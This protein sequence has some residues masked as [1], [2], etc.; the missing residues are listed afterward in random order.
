METIKNYLDN[1]FATL[2]KNDETL[3]LKEELLYN[4]EDK[5]NEL[6]ENG[7]TENEAIG[8]VISEF[9]NI[10]ELLEEFHI[11]SVEDNNNIRTIS[12][13]EAENFMMDKE[14]YGIITAIGVLLC[15]LAPAALVFIE[16]IISTNMFNFGVYGQ[17]S[18]VIGVAVL[19]IL[20]AIAV[21][22]F[23]YSGINLEKYKY[24]EGDFKLPHHVKNKIEKRKEEFASTF[25]GNSIAGVVICVLSPVALII[26]SSIKVNDYDLSNYG[27]VILLVMVAVAVFMFVRVGSVK[28]SYNMLLQVED[29]SEKSKKNSKVIGA[30]AAVVWPVATAIFLISGLMFGAWSICWIIFP[31]TGILFGAFSGAYSIMK[32]NSKE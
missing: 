24:L 1:I 25:T 15:I 5:Y 16:E 19:L 8:I 18:N 4:M 11:E 28:G 21:G 22:L 32:E 12:I 26:L 10:D 29:Y 2:P 14:K 20:I 30:V 7:K 6:K 17:I 13:E 3:K 23:I 27:V 9:G 31:I